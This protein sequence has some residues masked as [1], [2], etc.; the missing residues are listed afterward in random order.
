[1]SVV[2]E[3]VVAKSDV[4]V[5]LT[6]FTFVAEALVTERFVPVAFVNVTPAKAERFVTFKEFA[7]MLPEAVRFVEDTAARD[8]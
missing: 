6:K 2:P 4:P 3:T 7:A 8:D 5:A 1:M